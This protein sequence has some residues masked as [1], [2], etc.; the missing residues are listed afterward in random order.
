M[1]KQTLTLR[2][3]GQWVKRYKAPQ[4]YDD[5]PD[6]TVALGFLRKYP[7]YWDLINPAA[8]RI[9]ELTSANQRPSFFARLRGSKGVAKEQAT[10]AAYRAQEAAA[11]IALQQA[12]QAAAASMT[13]EELQ[14]HRTRE[15]QVDEQVRLAKNLAAIDV[16]KAW[17][18]S[19][20]Q[21]NLARQ[22]AELALE[23]TNKKAKQEEQINARQA[24]K[25]ARE[26]AL[27]EPERTELGD[28]DRPTSELDGIQ[29]DSF[30]EAWDETAE[31]SS[32]HRD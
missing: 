10:N 13:P 30:D 19:M 24:K 6:D 2:Q 31:G 5:L 20:V 11:V 21:L 27:P 14:N 4:L 22:E 1:T 9:H 18:L 12:A 16:E 23:Y 15:H 32:S 3:L 17:K 26:Y 28:M 7:A 29:S 25:R 8:R